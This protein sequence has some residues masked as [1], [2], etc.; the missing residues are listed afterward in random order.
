LTQ[1][2]LGLAMLL[3]GTQ[4]VRA[5]E[6]T[7]QALDRLQEQ[8]AISPERLDLV[9]ALG[10]AAVL[11]GKLDIA[12]ASFEK[13]LQNL[14]PES[15]EA[16]DLHL[17]IGE[18]YRRKGDGEAAIASLTR[19]SQLLPDQPVVVGTLALVL[20]G[21]GKKNEAEKAYRATLQ[22]DPDNT[23]AMNNLA[24]LLAERGEDLDQALGFARRAMELAPEDVEIIDTAGWV[25]WKRGQT[26]EA[27]G[28][29]AE[30]LGK[31]PG[32]DGYR[33]HLV[34]ALE[35]KSSQSASMNEL[36]ALL[37]GDLSPA[38]MERAQELLQWVRNSIR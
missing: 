21:F 19:A 37:S 28:L 27:I 38:S 5:Q 33:R 36:K 25:Q 3:S 34:L 13:V 4:T 26:D 32:N 24:F 6:D 18:T 8:I 15:Q 31:T 22:L 35:M 23:I 1:V 20:D 12:I 9:L 16:G 17:R 29:F 10:N 30:A 7:G 11:A 2:F 14:E